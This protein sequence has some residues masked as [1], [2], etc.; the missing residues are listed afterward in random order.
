M[1]NAKTVTE[2][3]ITNKQIEALRT[4]AAEACDNALVAACD[5]AL[6]TDNLGT[7]R[8]TARLLCVKAINDAGAQSDD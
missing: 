6:D 5:A 2:M 8:R 3:T 4:E 1:S 7:E